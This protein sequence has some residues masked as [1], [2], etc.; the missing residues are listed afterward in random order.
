MYVHALAIYLSGGRVIRLCVK[1]KDNNT[2]TK[3]NNDN[4]IHMYM[5]KCQYNVQC[6][7]HLSDWGQGSSVSVQ[8]QKEPEGEGEKKGKMPMCNI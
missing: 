8:R 5:Y 6:C 2:M 4:N 7:A 1:P 3:Q